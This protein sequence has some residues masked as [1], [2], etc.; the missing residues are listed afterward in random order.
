VSRIF[1]GLSAWRRQVLCLRA[2]HT[3]AV[4]VADGVVA[5]QALPAG[6][7]TVGQGHPR[8]VPLTLH[9][10]PHLP[11]TPGALPFLPATYKYLLYI[12]LLFL[13]LFF[14]INDFISGSYVPSSLCKTKHRFAFDSSCRAHSGVSLGRATI[15]RGDDGL[16]RL[17]LL[18]VALVGI[19]V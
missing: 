17:Y 1:A 16:V 5:G 15:S 2:E 3:F 19:I 10:Y 9:F 8:C 6:W 14:Y 7:R 11:T 4:C 12:S 13:A 18:D